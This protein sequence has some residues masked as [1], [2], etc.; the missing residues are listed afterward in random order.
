MTTPVAEKS[1]LSKMMEKPA[2]M[3]ENS[4][5]G[6]MLEKCRRSKK[7]VL[8]IV[9]IALLLDNMLLTIVGNNGSILYCVFA[10]IFKL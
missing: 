8:F 7:L 2:E 6:V 5:F 4:R 1:T 10:C 3:V 9:S